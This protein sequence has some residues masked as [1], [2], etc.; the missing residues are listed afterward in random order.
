MTS[1]SDSWSTENAVKFYSSHRNSVGE[2]YNSE[3]YFLSQVIESGFSILDLGC[4][5]GGFYQVFK[6]FEPTITYTGIDIS[7]EMIR[8]AQHRHPGIPFYVAEGS[9]LPFE[10]QS[11]DLVFCSGALHLA[12]DWREILHEGW[13]VTKKYFIFDIRMTET[14][15]TLEDI[16][17]SYEKMAF[18]NEWD[19]ISL[20]PYIIVNVN[21]FLSILTTLTPAPAVQ[22]LY[23]Y[24]HPVSEMT[25]SPE[26]H[27]CM[28]M[29]CLGKIKKPMEKSTW[30]IP[31]RKPH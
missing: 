14:S 7:G 18:N 30:E 23:G 3:K 31:I 8:R 25:V 29:C 4:A 6:R 19:G 17:V 26:K 16:H 11:F 28:T 12:D 27:V 2:M 20:V 24:Y 1:H 9:D 21:D 22:R 10:D 13:R 5:A 15:P